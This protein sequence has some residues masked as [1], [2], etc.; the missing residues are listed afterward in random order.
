MLCSW[1]LFA[2]CL[3][4]RWLRMTTHASQMCTRLRWLCGRSSVAESCHTASWQIVK[5]WQRWRQVDCGSEHR[6][7]CLRVCVRCLTRVGRQVRATAQPSLRSQSLSATLHSPT[8]KL[9]LRLF[10]D[11]SDIIRLWQV[12]LG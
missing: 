11:V 8:A 9:T 5:C 4:R 12:Y 2:G 7:P 1:F 6:S 3:S 10:S